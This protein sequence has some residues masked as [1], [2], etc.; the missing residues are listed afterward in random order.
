MD[1]AQIASQ[2]DGESWNRFCIEWKDRDEGFAKYFNL[3]SNVNRILSHA[4]LILLLETRSSLR[5]LD[6]SAGFCAIGLVAR[7]LGHSVTI[8]DVDIPVVKAA[9]QELKFTDRHFL[10]Y[11]QH[12]GGWGFT[13]I[14]SE[15]GKFNIITA[16][17]CAPHVWFTAEDW[18]NYYSDA[19]DHLEKGGI[20]FVWLNRSPGDRVLHDFLKTSNYK[21]IQENERWFITWKQG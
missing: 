8:T 7:A 2:V 3:E 15:C 9:Q 10:N 19:F 21:F 6:I 13:P 17:A 4:Q 5:L 11:R 1:S 16:I 20:A 14:P 12:S 18:E